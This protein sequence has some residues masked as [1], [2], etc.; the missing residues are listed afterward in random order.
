[1]TLEI[2]CWIFKSTPLW[3]FPG[4]ELWSIQIPWPCRGYWWFRPTLPYIGEV[5]RNIG[6]TSQQANAKHPRQHVL[7]IQVRH[8]REMLAGTFLEHC[9]TP[10]TSTPKPSNLC[11]VPPRTIEHGT[12]GI[13]LRI[14]NAQ[15]DQLA[16]ISHYSS[17]F[18][19][20]DC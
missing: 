20:F 13:D 18:R 17:Y 1:M 2:E 11:T 10:T 9:N 14:S 4:R 3:K 12:S 15:R 8:K 16:T 7:G 6:F 5:P 19:V